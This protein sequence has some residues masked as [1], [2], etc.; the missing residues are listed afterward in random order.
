MEDRKYKGRDRAHPA[1]STHRACSEAVLFGIL[2]F[3]C[4][5]QCH[6]KLYAAF[7]DLRFLLLC[8]IIGVRKTQRGKECVGT[9]ST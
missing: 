4:R 1:T 9:S 5:T 3:Y 2:I 7:V 6:A 8:D